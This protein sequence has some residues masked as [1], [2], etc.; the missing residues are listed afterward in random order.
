MEEK[1]TLVEEI[2]LNKEQRYELVD[3]ISLCLCLTERDL[4]NSQCISASSKLPIKEH[5]KN[6]I[7]RL[8]DIDINWEL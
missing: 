5:I 2:T 3:L 4:K 1:E 6:V 8:L 7:K